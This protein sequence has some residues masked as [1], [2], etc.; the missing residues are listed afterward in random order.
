LENTKPKENTNRIVLE[1][2]GVRE[3]V[4]EILEGGKEAFEKREKKYGF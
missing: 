4:C 1:S 3:H 2:Q